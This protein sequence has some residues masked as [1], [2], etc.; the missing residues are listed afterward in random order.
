MTLSLWTYRDL[1]PQVNDD[2]VKSPN[3]LVDHK[4]VEDLSDA[5]AKVLEK[6]VADEFHET[7]RLPVS[8]SSVSADELIEDD[9]Y[10]GC[11]NYNCMLERNIENN[12]SDFSSLSEQFF[13][14]HPLIISIEETNDPE[15]EKLLREMLAL[16]HAV[17][18]NKFILKIF[19]KES[20][21]ARAHEVEK[22]L[23]KHYESIKQ[24]KIKIEKKQRERI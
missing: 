16:E 5:F 14:K 17:L 24:L 4:D 3:K 15:E 23:E 22:T 8:V 20:D 13:G 6:N 2:F 21:E 12:D 11:E 18:E 9:P 1:N 7:E 19:E 10:E